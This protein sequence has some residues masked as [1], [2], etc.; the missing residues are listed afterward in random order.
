MDIAGT[1]V[2]SPGVLLAA[3]LHIDLCRRLSAACR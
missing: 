1:C 3:R 2:L